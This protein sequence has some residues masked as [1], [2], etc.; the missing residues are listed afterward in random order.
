MNTVESLSYDP[1]FPMS[2]LFLWD[3]IILDE[4]HMYRRHLF[5]LL[6]FVTSQTKESFVSRTNAL[7]VGTFLSIDDIRVSIAINT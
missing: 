5:L 1:Y 7:L 3:H 6:K 2:N 4:T